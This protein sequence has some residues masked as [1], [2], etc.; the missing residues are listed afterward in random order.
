MTFPGVK[1]FV[2][3]GFREIDQGV[4]LNGSINRKMQMI[5]WILVIMTKL[6]VKRFVIVIGQ[7]I[8]GLSPKSFYLVQDL[9]F[10]LDFKGQIVG[11]TFN[12]V[13]QPELTAELFG[14]L[15]EEDFDLGPPFLFL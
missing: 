10:D 1:D 7:I 13:F 2:V 4:I 11:I 9:V 6:L 8:F 14:I 15:F 3:D 5:L 12:D